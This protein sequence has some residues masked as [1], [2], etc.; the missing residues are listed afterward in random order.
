M[1]SPGAVSKTLPLLAAESSIV[2]DSGGK[3]TSIDRRQVLERWVLDYRVL[4]S[5]SDVQY[6]VA[7]RGINKTIAAIRDCANTAFTGPGAARAYLPPD[8]ASLVPLTQ[9]VG[10]ALDIA[11]V[12]TAAD[13]LPVDAPAANVILAKPLDGAWLGEPAIV[14]GIPVAPLPLVLADLLSLPGR[15]PQQAEALMDALAK[16]DPAWRA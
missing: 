14:N 1:V 2:R 4:T 7:P 8:V 16:I 11:D 15:Y 13:L 9:I 5:N 10:Y 12:A 6:F 3:V